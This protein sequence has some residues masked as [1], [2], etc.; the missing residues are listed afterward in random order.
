MTTGYGLKEVELTL[1]HKLWNTS[2]FLLFLL[3]ALASVGVAMLYSAAD[4]SFEPWAWRHLIR[5]AIGMALLFLVAL[6]DIRVWLRSAY[7]LYFGAFALLAAVEVMGAQ[8]MGA[9]RWVDLGGFRLQPSELMKIVL[10]VALARY[11]HGLTTD[12]VRRLP[13]LLVPAALVA[14]PAALV[15]RQPDLGTAVMLGLG[16]GAIFLVAGVRLWVL[17][18]GGGLGV[19]SVPVAWQFMHAYQK[20]RILTFL[21]PESDPLGAGYHI[22]QSKIALGSGGLF[23]KGF[24]QG[25]QSHLN[26]LP[27]KQTDFIFT[28][29]SEEFGIVGGLLLLSI[30]ALV[31]AYALLISVRSHNQFGRLLGMG[32]SVTFFLYVF[33]N[34]AMVTGLVPVVGVPLPL[35]SY[36]GSAMVTLLIGFGLVMNVH[37]HREIMIPRRPGQLV[38]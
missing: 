14:A 5:F 25:T 20:Q 3:S 8:G 17:G 7:L 12:Q 13:Y 1:A 24:L 22:L 9:Q 15:L 30:Y 26:F 33:I 21:N 36:G 29:L 37:I 32:V 27:E 38:V 31:L 19:L 35:V 10:V 28:T 34:I 6:I 4:G 11:F 18:L 23:G 16:G 2:W